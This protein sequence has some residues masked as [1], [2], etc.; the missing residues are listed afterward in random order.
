MNVIGQGMAWFGSVVNAR[1]LWRMDES[2]S[3]R[4]YDKRK[5]GEWETNAMPPKE[6]TKGVYSSGQDVKR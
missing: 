6:T 3:V 1:N 5:T 2:P 4:V